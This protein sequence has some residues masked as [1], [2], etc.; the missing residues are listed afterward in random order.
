MPYYTKL[1]TC[2]RKHSIVDRIRRYYSK[3][4]LDYDRE[5]NVFI[6]LIKVI[7]SIL[8]SAFCRIN[9]AVLILDLGNLNCVSLRLFV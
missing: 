7:L 3:M 4:L 5:V 6:E 8:S 1:L 9:I 2:T